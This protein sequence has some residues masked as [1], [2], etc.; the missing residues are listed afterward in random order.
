M[1][2]E[3]GNTTKAYL[4][5]DMLA[6]ESGLM[7]QR[8][9]GGHALAYYNKIQEKWNELEK[10][11]HQMKSGTGTPDDIDKYGKIKAQQA[12]YEELLSYL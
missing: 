12:K 1:D 11:C 7:V 2:E 5:Y 8:P 9:D 3:K 4:L 6:E 10:Q